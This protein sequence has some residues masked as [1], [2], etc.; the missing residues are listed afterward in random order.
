METETQRGNCPE[1]TQLSSCSGNWSLRFWFCILNHDA[2]PNT[3]ICHS[4]CTLPWAFCFSKSKLSFKV[5]SNKRLINQLTSR[6]VSAGR[7]R[8]SSVSDWSLL[9]DMISLVK[10]VCSHHRSEALNERFWLAS[11]GISTFILQTPWGTIFTIPH[12]KK[13]RKKR[14]EILST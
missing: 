12:Q 1:I 5:F 2:L 9:F 11:S 6:T 7:S 8:R 13:D 3:V 14:S 10:S 4:S